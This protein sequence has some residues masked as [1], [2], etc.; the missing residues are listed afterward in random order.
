MGHSKGPHRLHSPVPGGRCILHG[1]PGSGHPGCDH[2]GVGAHHRPAR[3][4]LDRQLLVLDRS[5]QSRCQMLSVLY[6]ATS[7][8]AFVSA[9][10]QVRLIKANRP[11]RHGLW[12]AAYIVIGYGSAIFAAGPWWGILALVGMAGIF[13]IN[14]RLFLN[15]LRGLPPD[16]MG[17]PADVI[18]NRSRYDLFY[19]RL[20]LRFNLSPALLAVSLEGLVSTIIILYFSLMR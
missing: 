19:W 9:W 8:G 2:C 7:T 15:S 10:W 17:P 1:H 6:L 16:Y 3:W 12:L 5:A 11:I 13:S 20:A 14:F 18:R 4:L